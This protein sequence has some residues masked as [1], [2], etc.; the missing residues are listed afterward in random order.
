MTRHIERK[1]KSNFT[2]LQMKLLTDPANKVI[3]KTGQNINLRMSEEQLWNGCVEMATTGGYPHS[4]IN[5]KGFQKIISP[6]ANKLKLVQK[7]NVPN[8][9]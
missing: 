9:K 8:L 3:Q 4:F 1:H 6:M 2:E 7:F 5:N